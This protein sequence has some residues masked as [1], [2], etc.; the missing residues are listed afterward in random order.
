MRTVGVIAMTC[1]RYCS[2]CTYSSAARS[3][4]HEKHKRNFALLPLSDRDAQFDCYHLSRLAHIP[5]EMDVEDHDSARLPVCRAT[6]KKEVE[7]LN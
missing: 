4:V 2:I 3:L 5:F 1:D 7:T 6:N